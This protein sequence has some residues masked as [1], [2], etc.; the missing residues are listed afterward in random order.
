MLKPREPSLLRYRWFRR[1]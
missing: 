1:L